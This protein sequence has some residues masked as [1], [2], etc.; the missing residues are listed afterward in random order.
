M[1]SYRNIMEVLVEQEARRQLGAIDDDRP[2]EISEVVSYALNRLPT[3][4]ASTNKGL[5]FQL[6][7]GHMDYGSQIF[8][9][10]QSAIAAVS[11]Q[12]QQT[13]TPIRP[14]DRAEWA[15]VVGG[16]TRIA[17]QRKVSSQWQS[18]TH[19]SIPGVAIR[20]TLAARYRAFPNSHPDLLAATVSASAVATPLQLPVST[21]ALEADG[22]P[23]NRL[24]IPA[25]DEI[26]TLLNANE[27]MEFFAPTAE[28][29][30]IVPS[31]EVAQSSIAPS[32]DEITNLFYAGEQAPAIDSLLQWI[33]ETDE[34]WWDGVF[35]QSKSA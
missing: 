22:T 12:P 17:K 9:V 6:K 27:G 21:S 14:E 35:S 10:V 8:Q 18:I 25:S 33:E 28:Q 2:L 19:P 24:P 5:K 3:L 16:A 4:Y 29:C 7:R 20:P 34:A 23:V 26:P 31:I 32:E 30:E 13:T 1:N 11:Q 15:E